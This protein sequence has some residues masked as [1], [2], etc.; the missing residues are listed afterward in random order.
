M[1][2]RYKESLVL[3]SCFW[4]AFDGP[5]F[6]KVVLLCICVSVFNCVSIIYMYVCDSYSGWMYGV[7]DVLTWLIIIVIEYLIALPWSAINH[8]LHSVIQFY[9]L[10]V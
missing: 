7:I 5:L 4:A 10:I 3:V 8:L 2:W 1:E 6:N 9:I